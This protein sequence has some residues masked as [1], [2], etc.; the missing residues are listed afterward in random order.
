MKALD[1]RFYVKL[2]QLEIGLFLL[3]PKIGSCEHS[4]NDLPTH[5]SVILCSSDTPFKR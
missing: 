5:G 1:N 4:K 2:M 3:D